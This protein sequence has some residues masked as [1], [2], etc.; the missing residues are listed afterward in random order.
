MGLIQSYFS[1]TQEYYKNYH[2]PN[3]TNAK[4]WKQDEEKEDITEHIKSF[5]GTDNHWNQ[6]LF[7]YGEVFPN[8]HNYHFYIE[9]L[10]DDNKKYWFHGTVGESHQIFNPRLSY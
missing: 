8:K 7:T 4:I 10:S 5:Y 3:L 2:G 1:N 6:Q 9:F